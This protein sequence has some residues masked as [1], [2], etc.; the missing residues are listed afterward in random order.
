MVII[1]INKKKTKTNNKRY[2]VDRPTDRPVKDNRLAELHCVPP[3]RF[4][5]KKKPYTQVVVVV[6]TIM[7]AVLIILLYLFILIPTP[8]VYG[9]H[10]TPCI[11]RI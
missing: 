6:I 4:V 5:E 2:I 10:Q 8:T 9:N 11:K 7:T 1:K 3:R